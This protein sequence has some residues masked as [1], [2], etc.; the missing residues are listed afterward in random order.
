MILQ[1]GTQIKNLK[2][3]TDTGEER[4]LLSLMGE[5]GMVLYFYPKDDTPGC[6]K[7]ACGF[8]DSFQEI[9]KLGYSIA[10]V[11]TDTVASHQKFK[12]K[13]NLNFPLIAD[14]NKELV[15]YFGVWGEKK[16]YGKT[17][18]GTLRTTFIIDRN[19]VIRKVYPKVKVE[20]HAGEILKDLQAL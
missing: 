1:E 5:A 11:S 12:A 13:Y 10:G 8:R 20:T 14:E 16:M 6:T 17:T 3:R 15:T 2:V 7:E 18:Y 4:D 19:L 9:K